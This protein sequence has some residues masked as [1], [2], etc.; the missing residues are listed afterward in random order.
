MEQRADFVGLAR[1][2]E[3]NFSELCR[4]FRISR[5]TGYKWLA[6]D[7]LQERSRRPH[8]SPNRTAQALEQQV[9][10]IRDRHPAW[11]ARK[12]AH[13]LLREQGIELTPSTVTSVLHRHGR[14]SAQASQAAT[15][16][17]RFL[18]IRN[19]THCGK[20]TSRATLPLPASA[21]TR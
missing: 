11:G 20:W 9:L 12:I 19:P 6:R 7:D 1:Q 3:A 8:S 5:E 17:Q 4:R 16:W 21:A 15:P 18:N 2:P 13:V 14:I 10:A